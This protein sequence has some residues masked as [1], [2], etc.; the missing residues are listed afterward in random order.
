MRSPVP[1]RIR[2][3]AGRVSWTVV[4]QVLS[5]LSNFLLSVLVARTV[6]ADVF[7]AFSMAFLI[8][9]FLIG[10]TR[11][12][13]GQPLQITFASAD[14]AAFRLATRS[15][16]GA[17]V[18]MGL[19]SGALCVV[20]GLFAGG[21]LATALIVLGVCLPGLLAQ[22]ISRMAFFARGRPAAAA[23]IDALWAALLF[24]AL[25][26]GQLLDLADIGWPLAFW[27]LSALAA[28]VVGILL[29]GA[30]PRLSGA[31]RWGWQQRPLTGYLLAEYI[32]TAGVGQIGILAVALTGDAAGVGALRAAQVLLGPL[33]ILVAASFLFAIPEI[34]RRP[35]ISAGSLSK[36][37]LTMIAAMGGITA[38]YCVVVLLI[39]DG[40]G[41][42]LLGDTWSGAQTVLLPMSVTAFFAALGTAP[43]SVLYG[44]GKANK[45]FSIQVWKAPLLVVLLAV[46]IPVWGAVGAAWA[47]AATEIITLPLWLVKARAAVRERSTP[48]GGKPPA[49]EHDPQTPTP[50]EG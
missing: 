34:A 32:M 16:L 43:A 38:V 17:A 29:L 40:I 3:I 28:A 37:G 8:F 50:A 30:G 19:V 5:A 4:D 24:P 15:A 26:V 10:I 20:A 1:V 22:D 23:G 36:L 39:P 21:E 6:T 7:G 46:G 42:S 14:D 41:R 25:L 45:T 9:T 11:A 18:L 33:G 48:A 47:I 49:V 35:D 31:A 2:K 27:G 13:I 12:L 44:L